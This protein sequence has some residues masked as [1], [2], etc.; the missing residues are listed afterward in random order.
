M[1]E[2]RCEVAGTGEVARLGIGLVG[3]LIRVHVFRE[4][5]TPECRLGEQLEIVGPEI[6][7]GVR[8]LEERIRGVPV[9]PEDRGATC[10]EGGFEDLAHVLGFPPNATDSRGPQRAGSPEE[11]A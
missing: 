6:A 8:L 3:A 2:E 11:R 9:A 7:R 4:E 1:G 5:P 10:F